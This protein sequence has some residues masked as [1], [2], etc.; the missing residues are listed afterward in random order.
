MV[1]YTLKQ[2]DNYFNPTAEENWKQSGGG[3]WF[4]IGADWT[5]SYGSVRD[6]IDGINEGDWNLLE[7]WNKDSKYDDDL[8]QHKN[9][10]SLEFQVNNPIA[11]TE[12]SRAIYETTYWGTQ[13]ALTVAAA[14]TGGAGLVQ[15]GNVGG[16]V[17]ALISTGT[18]FK[19]L[20]LVGGTVADTLIPGLMRDFTKD[21]VGMMRKEGVMEQLVNAYGEDAEF[22][23]PALAAKLNSP[24]AK[25]L[26]ST[27]TEGTAAIVGGTILGKGVPLLYK[28]FLGKTGFLRQ[29]LPDAVRLA[30]KHTYDLG[31]S[32]RAHS[33]KLWGEL[34]SEEGLYKRSERQLSDL[35]EA[36]NE[37]LR[38][39]KD[40]FK[41]AF[42]G[43]DQRPG[44][45]HST[46]GAYKNGAKL[47][48]QVC[49]EGRKFGGAAHLDPP[50]RTCKCM[51]CTMCLPA[52]IL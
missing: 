49:G 42:V 10:L 24:W 26:D 28:T 16:K 5:E 17:P 36:G 35:F 33:T 37:Q 41:N 22:I 12:N 44:I 45:M 29:G 13:L 3:A 14:Q 34:M 4:D 43:T 11:I 47:L 48:G 30:S 32:T 23:T 25:R 27:L 2:R 46:Y 6:V 18:K 21:G 50:G 31:A 20:G 8:L 51:L 15:L 38:K 7:N 52:C 19:N 1:L 39:S 9:P 40:N